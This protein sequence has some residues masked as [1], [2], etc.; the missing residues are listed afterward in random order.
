MSLLDVLEN[1]GRLICA[2]M[3][4]AVKGVVAATKHPKPE[5]WKE[6]FIYDAKLYFSPL[7]GAV[8]EVENELRRQFGRGSKPKD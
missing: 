1:I 2:P 3:V 5:N 4:G 6:F 7:T 8:N